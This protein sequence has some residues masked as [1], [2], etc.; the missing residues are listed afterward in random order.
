MYLKIINRRF[1]KDM[2]KVR[3]D[4]QTIKPP[5]DGGEIATP[6]S[7]PNT[8]SQ[9]LQPKK[10]RL[11]RFWFGLEQNEKDLFSVL[12]LAPEDEMS[13]VF[14]FQITKFILSKLFKFLR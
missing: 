9:L 1:M 7:L 4:F 14:V 13:N 2:R 12:F 11:N 6:I 8:K 3:E 5:S 10:I